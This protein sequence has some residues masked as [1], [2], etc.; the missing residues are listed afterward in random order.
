[1]PPIR[2]VSPVARRPVSPRR[3]VATV[4]PRRAVAAPV[5]VGGGSRLC[6]DRII[7]AGAAGFAAGL[8]AGLAEGVRDGNRIGAES[9][10]AFLKN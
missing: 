1:M 2:R 10:L 9:A 8:K 7:L 6:N 4:S 3:A 5:A